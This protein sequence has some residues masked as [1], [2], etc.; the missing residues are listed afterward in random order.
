[1]REAEKKEKQGRKRKKRQSSRQRVAGKKN[2]SLSLFLLT[3]TPAHHGEEPRPEPRCQVH[4]DAILDTRNRQDPLLDR[5]V[6][7]ELGGVDDRVARD[8]G[9]QTRPERPEPLRPDD[10]SVRAQ[11]ARVPPDGP[12]RELPLGLHAD[13]HE[14]GG[15]RDAD[16]ERACREPGD[17]FQAEAVAV[18]AGRVGDRA[19]ERV[20]EDILSQKLRAQAIQQ[21]VEDLAKQKGL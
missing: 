16:G 15:A 6:A 11:G 12:R 18:G 21:E 20:V 8:V 7:R 14:V 1:M 5:V 17:D 4:G 13:F 2:V 10:R 3:W 19:L 9:A